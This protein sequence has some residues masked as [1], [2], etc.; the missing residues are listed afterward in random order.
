[1][2][3]LGCCVFVA[4]LLWQSA[5]PRSAVYFEGARLIIGDGHV[6]EDSAFV[7][8]AGRITAVGKKG[9]IPPP[10]RAARVDLTG[11]TIMPAMVNVHVHI[12]YEGYTSWGA[13]NYPPANVLDPLRREAFYGVGATQSVGSSPTEQSIQFQKDQQAGKF[14]PSSRFFFMPGMAPANGGPDAILIKGTTAL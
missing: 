12:G 5:T 4:A 11:K 13:Q 6:V 14:P 10:P 7:I 2:K 9:A 8:E 1:M 3:L